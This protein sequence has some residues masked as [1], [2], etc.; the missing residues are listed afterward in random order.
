MV[1][2]EQ[3]QT[4]QQRIGFNT[5]CPVWVGFYFLVPGETQIGTSL[6]AFLP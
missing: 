6:T 4:V 2:E 1:G 5:N 3:K